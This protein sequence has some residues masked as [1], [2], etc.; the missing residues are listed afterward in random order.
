MKK[1]LMIQFL[2]VL[3][4]DATLWAYID[5]TL[6]TKSGFDRLLTFTDA[7]VEKILSFKSSEMMF[8]QIYL[9]AIGQSMKA[10]LDRTILGIIQK[11][12][13]QQNPCVMQVIKL[14]CDRGYLYLYYKEE[15]P[16]LAKLI[17][18]AT[19]EY[20]A[21]R[22]YQLIRPVH[23]NNKDLVDFVRIVTKA[24]EEY[25]ANE[26]S[27]FIIMEN[28][29]PDQKDPQRIKEFAAILANA[30]GENQAQCASSAARIEW[31]QKSDNALALVDAIAKSENGRQAERAVQY[32]R[33]HAQDDDTTVM[34]IA[35]ITQGSIQQ[36]VGKFNLGNHDQLS[37]LLTALSHSKESDITPK[38][39]VKIYGNDE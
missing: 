28:N 37:M 36:P 8:A 34:K 29:N 39:M 31:V 20:Q 33:D 22:G 1:E 26:A 24:K 4:D 25:Q 30:T 15:V 23:C 12:V 18:E 9:Y 32:L 6:G 10:E 14:H 17:A 2:T 3:H 11:A 19:G 38:T 27:Q 35:S 16:E 21:K 13:D 7:Q 5:S